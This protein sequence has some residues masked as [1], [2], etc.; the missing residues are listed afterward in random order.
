MRFAYAEAMCDPTFY[1][2]LARA[3]EAAGFDTYLV[4]DSVCYP[5]Q[6]SSK[7]PYTPDGTREFLEDKPFI[8]PFALMGA[9]TAVTTRLQ[10]ATFVLKLPIRTPVIV[11]KSITSLAVLSGNRVSLG[12]GTSPWPEDFEATGEDW[13]TRGPR[14]DEMIDIIRG[15]AAG[16]YF[17]YRGRHYQIP[18]IKMCPA[19]DR[20][21]PILVGGHAEP[22]LR[23]AARMGDGFMFAGGSASELSGCLTRLR[24]LRQEYGRTDPFAIYASSRDGYTRD[25]VKRLADLGVTDLVV[26][27]RQPYVRG[28]DTEP[29]Q[30]KLDA[31]AWYGDAIIRE[32]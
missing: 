2:P 20:P 7:Y 9:M 19:P 23:R 14:T 6:S 13:K 17:E 18:R 27:F 10:F 12:I 31:L 8:E 4:P 26:G 25:G 5:E 1:L 16:G 30:K 32:S 15:L 29:L 3:A 11:A 22:A 28:P 24:E 21:I